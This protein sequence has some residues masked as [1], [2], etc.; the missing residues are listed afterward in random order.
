MESYIEVTFLTNGFIILLSVQIAQYI[1]LRPVDTKNS[2]CYALGKMECIYAYHFRTS[3]L[4]D[5]V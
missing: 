4:S 1:T 3:I 5:I 2:I